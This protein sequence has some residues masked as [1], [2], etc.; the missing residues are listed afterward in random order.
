MSE[1]PTR[2]N[3]RLQHIYFHERPHIRSEATI[4][5]ELVLAGEGYCFTIALKLLD[6]D[7]PEGSVIFVLCPRL[8]GRHLG[9][10]RRDGIHR[11]AG[12][13]QFAKGEDRSGYDIA[14]ALRGA[15]VLRDWRVIDVDNPN[16][17]SPLAIEIAEGRIPAGSEFSIDVGS[18][19]GSN[20]M[21]GHVAQWSPFCVGV[22]FPDAREVKGIAPE[23]AR[24]LDSTLWVRVVGSVPDKLQV[25]APSAVEAGEATT[26]RVKVADRENWNPTHN[27]TGIL[28]FLPQEGVEFPDRCQ[29]T[30]DG[31]GLLD[32]PARILKEGTHRIVAYDE[33]RGL[34][35][36]SNP[37]STRM[38]KR[39][40]R[41]YWGDFHVHTLLCD[42]EG[43][44]E[45][46]FRWAR[47][48]LRLDWCGL[49]SHYYRHLTDHYTPFRAPEEYAANVASAPREDLWLDEWD[50]CRDATREFNDP[51][52]FVT[53]L[54]YEE[55][56]YDGYRD[57]NI[58]FRGDDGPLVHMRDLPGTGLGLAENLLSALREVDCL[59]IPH[60]PG[61]YTGQFYELRDEQRLRLIE[62]FSTW[63]DSESKDAGRVVRPSVRTAGLDTGCRWGFTAGTD[64]H[65]GLPGTGN[66]RPWRGGGITAVWSPA[67][68]RDGIFDGLQARHT[69]AS[70][71]PRSIVWMEV[72]NSMVGDERWVPSRDELFGHTVS[73]EIAA[74]SPVV[75]VEVIRNGEIILVDQPNAEEWC[76]EFDDADPAPPVLVDSQDPS[77]EFVYYYTRV[78]HDTGDI[79]W[80]SP[81][82]FLHRR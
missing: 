66:F 19:L 55:S 16:Y 29:L 76:V 1:E 46:A 73:I 77:V 7:L 56:A 67:L 64:N 20:M 63:G 44:P 70:T 62:I 21:A 57:A 39:G 31:H 75:R 32:A 36:R 26:V 61:Y 48:S 27:Y 5:P 17:F 60:H 33:Q 9:C 69:I 30:P 22:L 82:W 74:A 8:F 45:D 50:Y 15:E 28:R 18:S 81:V 37:M 11:L 71:G 4:S 49:G 58:Y 41:P 79:V 68:T 80:A 53:L 59:V 38:L 43:T 2:L 47:D 25:W 24:P 42:G 13:T 78:T 65:S 52:R 51:G 34:M 14:V 3:S 10:P 54:G 72:D 12:V 6:E 23:A 35:G 40:L